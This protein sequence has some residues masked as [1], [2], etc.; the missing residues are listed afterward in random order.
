MKILIKIGII[1]AFLY[2]SAYGL[3][4]GWFARFINI[5]PTIEYAKLMPLDDGGYALLS[6]AVAHDGDMRSLRLALDEEDADPDLIEIINRI[7]GDDSFFVFVKGSVHG[8]VSL[9]SGKETRGGSPAT[10]SAAG[11]DLQLNSSIY[12]K[13]NF[14][15]KI[16]LKIKEASLAGSVNAK[17][18]DY[19]NKY[20]LNRLCSTNL[21][22]GCT[23]V[24]LEMFGKKPKQLSF[25]NKVQLASTIFRPLSAHNAK[26][27]AEKSTIYCKSYFASKLPDCVFSENEF[28]QKWNIISLSKKTIAHRAQPLLQAKKMRIIMRMEKRMDHFAKGVTTELAIGGIHNQPIFIS[29][30][31][32]VRKR[33]FDKRPLASVNKLMILLIK[34]LTVDEELLQ[35]MRVSSNSIIQQRLE[36]L[37]PGSIEEIIDIIHDNNIN[38]HFN[39]PSATLAEALANGY[40]EADTADTLRLLSIIGNR[41]K[42]D[43]N[44]LELATA[45]ISKKGTGVSILT[46]TLS[47]HL[48]RKYTILAA[49]TGTLASR[50]TTTTTP[51]VFG[52]LFTVVLYRKHDAKIIPIIIRVYPDDLRSPICQ[53][54]G[55]VSHKY[56]AGLLNEAIVLIDDI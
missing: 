8:L 25:K 24:S 45:S 15:Q 6:Q 23:L 28:Q 37:A 16:W 50:S 27:L 29:N 26:K 11:V 51:G 22:R 1:V 35:G 36:R 54:E 19:R 34:N 49:K 7:E 5:E 55:C 17:G 4:I 14:L 43:N 39:M 18:I 48:A 9:V 46:P 40:V 21:L 56:L 38:L 32:I 10:L 2:L 30:T 3:Y 20:A 33:G 31:A 42:N 13:S 41:V 53:A 44:L 47:T 52:K 12:Q